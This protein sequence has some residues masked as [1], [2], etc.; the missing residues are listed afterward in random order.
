MTHF[1]D[2]TEAS[3]N[4]YIIRKPGT[5]VYVFR[6]KNA[7]LTFIVRT[8]RATVWIFGTYD[9]HNDENYRLCT[10]QVHETANSSSHLVIKSALEDASGL[11]HQGMIHIQKPASNTNASL[12][13]RHLLLGANAHATAQPNLEIESDDVH[14]SH[15]VTTSPLNKE[16]IFFLES[17]GVLPQ[18]A[19][20][21]IKKGFLSSI[22]KTICELKNEP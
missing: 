7:E 1:L 21:I 8:P 20:E 17:R 14:C 6:N 13:S 18:K 15:A 2:I 5:Y 9:L 3:E 4:T 22:E 12:E 10:K 11:S 19:K 16:S